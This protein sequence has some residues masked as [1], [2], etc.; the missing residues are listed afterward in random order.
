MGHYAVELSFVLPRARLMGSGVWR[1]PHYV[2]RMPAYQRTLETVLPGWLSAS[3]A[4]VEAGGTAAAEWE[5]FKER[6]RSF[7]RLFLD[8]Y[9]ALQRRRAT[10]AEQTLE[11][12]DAELEGAGFSM[13]ASQ[14][15]LD[16]AEE[17]HA[18]RARADAVAAERAGVRERDVHGRGTREFHGMCERRFRAPPEVVTD[19][20]GAASI[21]GILE[22]VAKHYSGDQP[23]G[24]FALAD[25]NRAAQDR[26][27]AHFEQRLTPVE[28]RDDKPCSAGDL[29]TVLRRTAGGVAPG[30]DGLPFEWYRAFPEALELLAMVA[31]GARQGGGLPASMR[32]SVIV[33]IYKGSGSRSDISKWRP[34]SLID[35]DARLVMGHMQDRLTPGLSRLIG[36]HQTAFLPG[37]S[38]VDVG[39]TAL[40]VVGY[41]SR[42][43]VD[44]ALVG[45]DWKGAY[46]AVDRGW[47]VRVMLHVGFPVGLVRLLV[48]LHTGTSSRVVINGFL[49]MPF[50][51]RRGVRQGDPSAPL[52]YVLALEPLFSYVGGGWQPGYVPLRLP[53]DEGQ[54]GVMGYADD[55]TGV[56]VAGPGGTVEV[57]PL[58][59]AAQLWG[60]ATGGGLSWG[61]SWV[62]CARRLT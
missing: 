38:I 43:A 22:A 2:A 30:A 6:V 20:G 36:P 17:S 29:L 57:D 8:D 45:L 46:D 55:T 18:E 3:Q 15:Y 25:V 10:R 40:E 28:R 23:G 1:L 33:L 50:P 5:S 9:R 26:L 41:T 7:S 34:I 44:G 11:D 16:A 58:L 21:T 35:T 52:L 39:L 37:R 61:K 14:R 4:R 32:R 59:D 60:E 24:V 51:V 13:E 27:L 62:S 54:V 48:C 53:D 56:V 31:E 19:M 42:E 47:L 49:S 12:M